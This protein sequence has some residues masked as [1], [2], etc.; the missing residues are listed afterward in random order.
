MNHWIP[1][2]IGDYER[3]TKDLTMIEDGAYF[4]LLRYCWTTGQG[5][6]LD[7][8]TIFR[9]A[10]AFTQEEQ[11]VTRKILGKFFTKKS[12]GFFNKKAQEIAKKQKEKM[13]IFKK[14]GSLGGRP[15]KPGGYENKNQAVKQNK[16]ACL[17][18][19]EPEPEPNICILTTTTTNHDLVVEEEIKNLSEPMQKAL[20]KAITHGAQHQN[21]SL[22]DRSWIPAF[23]ARNFIHLKKTYPDLRPAD[24]LQAWV[25]ACTSAARNKGRTQKY[26]ET[27]F[28]RLIESY[29]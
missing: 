24:L 11:E 12:T 8:M 4:R 19:P 25:D 10:A 7:E 6:P 29:L 23:L 13:E 27:A 3:D 18:I 5:L 1:F 21:S 20:E 28:L 26:Y 2:Y 14:N 15:R 22:R 16:T 17:T 9:I